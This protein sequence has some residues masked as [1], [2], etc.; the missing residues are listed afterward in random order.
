MNTEKST[1]GG[2]KQRVPQSRVQKAPVRRK[3]TR[4]EWEERKRREEERRKERRSVFLARTVVVLV[5]YLAACIM[6]AGLVTV[7]YRGNSGGGTSVQILGNDGK[8]VYTEAAYTSYRDGAQYIS[9]T[10]LSELYDFTLAGDSN[11]VTMYFHNIGEKIVFTDNSYVVEINGV[12]RRLSS[13]IV[14]KNDYY[15]PLELIKNYF[16][17]ITIG[18]SKRGAITLAAEGKLSLRSFEQTATE[19]S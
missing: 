16:N 18:R 8:A 5:I 6:I 14:F 10:G 13:A 12:K 4:E 11:Q 9:A 15:I 2:V 3:L 1:N 19:P 7:L 17:G